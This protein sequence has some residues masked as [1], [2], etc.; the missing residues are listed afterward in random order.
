MEPA[1]RSQELPRGI[2][3]VESRQRFI[4]KFTV[5]DSAVHKYKSFKQLEDAQSALDSGKFN[6]AEDEVEVD[7]EC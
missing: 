7:A 3:W 1:R 4:V 6:L 2:R 5:P